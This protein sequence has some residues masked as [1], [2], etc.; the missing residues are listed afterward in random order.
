[1]TDNTPDKGQSFLGKLPPVK[2]NALVQWGYRY[3][4]LVIL[5][6][7]LLAVFG[8][9]ALQIMNK[10]EFPEFTI[11]EGVLVAVM[12]GAT[13]QEMEEQ[14]MRPMEDF[15][16]SY[17]EVNKKK[18][19]SN[20]TAGMVMTF[21]ELD[22]NVNDANA[23]WTKFNMGIPGLKRSL[24][25][26]TLGVELISNFGE[27]SAILLTMQSN[28]KTYR[29]LKGYMDRLEDDLRSIPSVGTLSVTGMIDEQISVTVNPDRLSQY[30][31][32]EKTIAGALF[33]QGLKTT[34]GNIKSSTYTS[35]IFVEKAANSVKEIQDLIILALPTGQTVRLGDVAEV[36]REYPDPSTG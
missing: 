14:V 34:G 36:K 32:N 2:P 28:Q 4:S 6:V 19:R 10:N 1:M 26:A 30:A 23:F 12:P 29:E 17:K 27:T 16:F 21:I 3:H 15:I 20:A 22:D 13:A 31:I 35:P 24:P 18:T 9:Y 5:L 11:R 7:T 8:I 33:A 25:D